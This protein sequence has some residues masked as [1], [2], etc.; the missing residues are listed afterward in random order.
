MTQCVALLRGINV[1]RAKRISMPDLRDLIEALGFSDVR[2]LLNSGNV[3]FQAR[4][5]NTVK[6][7]S[8]IELSVQAKF[9]FSAHTVVLTAEELDAIVAGNTLPQ[10]KA[11]PSRFL[12]AFVAYAATLSKAQPLLS[13]TWEPDVLAIGNRAAYL[14]C[15]SG[16]IE[17]KLLLA[18]TRATEQATTTRNWTTVLKLQALANDAKR[19]A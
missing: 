2:T 19:A 5:P 7:A 13:Q 18:F 4:R 14:W 8:A 10:A 15:A 11:E 16:I 3:V 12:V 6:I 1:G 9:G 17:S